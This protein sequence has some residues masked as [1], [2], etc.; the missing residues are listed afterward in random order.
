MHHDLE[1]I[2]EYL[3]IASSRALVNGSSSCCA[4]IGPPF[5]MLGWPRLLP[6]LHFEA[7]VGGESRHNESRKTFVE[8]FS[9]SRPDGPQLAHNTP[10]V[11][12]FGSPWALWWKREMGVPRW[13][14][15]TTGRS[16]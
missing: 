14:F 15:P 4:S 13:S 1:R 12:A 8:I 5:G 7:E 11:M 16:I 3:H 9:W 10:A 6:A 2:H